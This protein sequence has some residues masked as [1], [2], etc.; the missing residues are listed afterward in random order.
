MPQTKKTILFFI[1]LPSFRNSLLQGLEILFCVL[2]TSQLRSFT[3]LRNI[4]Y[5]KI[6][7]A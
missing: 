4:V 6:V 2:A 7:L 5:A 1:D 3:E